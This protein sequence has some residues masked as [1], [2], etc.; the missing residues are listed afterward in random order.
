[1]EAVTVDSALSVEHIMPQNWV[2][3]WPLPNGTKGMAAL[4]LLK[5]DSSNST[6]LATRSRNSAVQTFGNLTILT[7][8]LNSSVSNSSWV[9][10][11][12]EL[13][14]HS[15]LPINQL[16][17]DK[18]AWNELVIAERGDALLERA[19]KIWPKL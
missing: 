8:E 10:K 16:L 5:A 9:L 3:H 2:D 13:L 6:A 15:L 17:Q 11:K 19:L 4:D 12:P 1:M 7:Q 18:Q 14:K